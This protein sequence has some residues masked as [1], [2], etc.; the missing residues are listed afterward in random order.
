MAEEWKSSHLDGKCAS[1]VG[2]VYD[3][4][5]SFQ[6]LVLKQDR[7]GSFS[8]QDSYSVKQDRK[9]N[10]QAVEIHDKMVSRWA[11]YKCRV[12]DGRGG[13]GG[14]FCRL[15]KLLTQTTACSVKGAL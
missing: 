10:R 13:G 15:K 14:G 11:E 8:I 5:V 6:V 3:R 1:Q 7:M 2:Y 4:L 12:M 9:C